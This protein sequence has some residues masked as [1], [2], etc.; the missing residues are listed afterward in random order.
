MILTS[1]A[2]EPG[3][4][5]ARQQF[6]S[7]DNMTDSLAALVALVHNGAGDSEE[8]L[9]EFRQ[10]WHNDPLVMDKW[11][12]L[13]AASPAE[14]T[15]ERVLQLMGDEVFSIGN[16]NKV[17]SLIGAFSR[18]NQ[19]CFH[20]ADGRGYEF[21]ADQVLAIDKLNPQVAARL[22]GA[23]NAW[24]R[25]DQDRQAMMRVALERVMAEAG[26]SPGVFEIVSKALAMEES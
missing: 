22:V 13:Q 19:V 1:M 20:A 8:C 17:R 21:L 15:L 7:A 24:T 6:R 25:F 12:S 18:L 23:F 14:G 4:G 9:G 5:L 26:L 2:D 11:L 16:P 3:F 10:R